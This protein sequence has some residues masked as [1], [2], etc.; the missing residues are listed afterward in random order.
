[1]LEKYS[2]NEYL[3]G[4]DGDDMRS[5]GKGID[6][7]NTGDMTNNPVEYAKDRIIL[8]QNLIPTL[9]ETLKSKSD[10]WESVYQGYRI[11]LR[12]IHT[13]AEIISRQIGGVYVNG[14]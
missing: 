1:M 2:S 4:N 9:Y 11:L 6:R 7:I 3:F 12:Q 8:S 10:S 14:V 13:S 5:P